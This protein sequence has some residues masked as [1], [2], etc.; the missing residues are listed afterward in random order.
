MSNESFVTLAT[1]ENYV[2]GALTLAQSLRE[3]GTTRALTVLITSGVAAAQQ[4]QLRRAFDQ[5]VLVDALDSHDNLNLALLKR[6]ELGVTF[7]KL[8]CWRL[9]QF[10]KCVFLDADCLVL[11]NVDE[12]FER[13]EFS[14][15]ADVG[16][17]DCFNSGVFVFRPS[18]ETYSSLLNFAVQR[19]SF[20]GGDQGLLNL[21][22][23]TWST[24]ESS[25][26]LPFV[27]NMTTN[28]SYSYAP[29]YKQFQDGVKIVHFI[30]AQKPWY[31]SYNVDTGAVLGN[32]QTQES[33]LLN[34]WWS[35]FV[36]NVLPRIDE[37]TRNR[38]SVQLIRSSNQSSTGSQWQG[39][40]ASSGNWQGSSQGSGAPSGGSGVVIGSD[41]HQNLW[42]QG[43][44]E[45][46]GRDSFS[47]IKAHLDAQLQ[48][49]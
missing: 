40:N 36:A 26:R 14:A 42:E 44:I 24:G 49:K 28:V 5:V 6:P 31:Y 17:P 9:T 8:H 25:R 22:F 48:K 32:V 13:D 41:Q 34:R 39:A 33:N 20:D 4:D 27:Y 2:L 11:Q 45:Y 35:T 30:G 29:A 37:E 3:A 47:N 1:N 7:T 16:W 10:S 46:T 19:G 21:F 15:A 38:L 43:K 12:L 23:N 18:L